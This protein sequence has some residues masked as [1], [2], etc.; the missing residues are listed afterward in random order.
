[1]KIH[2]SLDTFKAKNTILTIGM[3]DGIHKGHL[4]ILNKLISDKKKYGG[5]TVLLTFWPHP[6]QY[7]NKNSNFYLLQTLEEKC[8][9]LKTI[10]I[11]H[12]I[13]LEFNDYLSNL[14]P[15]EYLENILYKGINPFKII[16][17]YD[18]RYGKKGEGDFALLQTF[19]AEKNIIIEEISAKQIEEVNISSTKV[20]KAITE[21]DIKTA[22]TYLGYNYSISGIVIKGKKIGRTIG[23]PTAN[24]STLN[25]HKLFPKNG[26]YA[27][28]ICIENKEYKAA[29]SIGF[30]P[31]INEQ[32]SQLYFEVYI[33]DFSDNIYDK[34]VKVTFTEKIRDEQKF[35]NL[36][37]LKHAINQDVKKVRE[38][39]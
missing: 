36:D 9:M 29:I 37:A 20:R 22:H 23:F 38:L 8:E 30:N 28:T 21:G 25:P 17:G 1:M 31:T 18:H 26:I 34:I 14:T 13:V 12:C 5:E 10:G 3:F 35:D 16:V 27:G 11:D 39:I 4:S 19:A 2:T 33:L 24:I 7:F 15:L 32:K 6:Q